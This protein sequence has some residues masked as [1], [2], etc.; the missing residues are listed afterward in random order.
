MSDFLNKYPYTDFHELNLD[1]VIERVKKLTEDWLAT[2]EEWHNT[3]EQW[4]QLYDYV[5]DYFAN[6]DVQD[7][8]NNKINQMILDGTFM[9]VVA[10]TINQTVVDATTAWLAANITQPT[11][12]VVD[13]SLTVAGAAAD[14]KITGFVRD[15]SDF[16]FD[17]LTGM[18]FNKTTYQFTFDDWIN[19]RIKDDESIVSQS[20]RLCME[21]YINVPTDQTLSNDILAGYKFIV[22]L[23]D[24]DKTRL[25]YNTYYT[26]TENTI[27]LAGAHYMRLMIDRADGT[28]ID[29]SEGSSVIF[30][31]KFAKTDKTLLIS[32]MPA[33]SQVT[34]YKIDKYFDINADLDLYKHR[35]INTTYRQGSILNPSASNR[36]TTSDYIRV[37]SGAYIKNVVH[38]GYVCAIV[39]YDKDKNVVTDE[40]R[41]MSSLNNHKINDSVCYVLF[42]IRRSDGQ[43][44]V[45][46]EGANITWYY[47]FNEPSYLDNLITKIGSHRYSV[48]HRG[49]AGFFP[50]N[51]TAAFIA[52]G[53]CGI[54]VCEADVQKTSDDVWVIM[55]DNTIDRTTDGSGDIRSM[56]YAQ[57]QTY[58]IDIGG[59]YSDAS[60]YTDLKIPTLQEYLEICKQYDMFPYVEFKKG[61]FETDITNVRA[62]L[63][64]I[65][66]LGFS[67]DQFA[68]LTV[69]KPVV[70]A[71]KEYD[72]RIIVVYVP[73]TA[74]TLQDVNDLAA[75]KPIIFSATS[76]DDLTPDVLDACNANGL[77][78][79][80]GVST[81]QD[82]YDFYNI[83]NTCIS[84]MSFDTCV[85]R[86]N[87]NECISIRVPDGSGNISVDLS[88]YI[89]TLS[90]VVE[91]SGQ[92]KASSNVTATLG[93]GPGSAD[94]GIMAQP[95]EWSD[96]YYSTIPVLDARRTFALSGT[97]LKHK[98]IVINI[99]KN[100]Y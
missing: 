52:A 99:Y 16:N 23:Y 39:G 44:I 60:V 96:F 43:D 53:M 83:N 45:P 8:I 49:L 64:Y 11:T 13:T 21:R 82:M 28:D 88:S 29:V 26:N 1:W 79:N 48:A 91:V 46:S 33:D 63:D 81:V 38:P 71:V 95:D 32:D 89:T 76:N 12:P 80:I 72:N 66:S 74:F 14:A 17:A 31:F 25:S 24:E 62:C 59:R 30:S 55:H 84:F 85:A 36:I 54:R 93:G 34:G 22:I 27:S 69:S 90:D 9:T 4:Q 7:E 86:R 58:N 19:G 65:R 78:I 47:D 37:V 40:T 5:H 20:N 94:Y 73:E 6:L 61:T 68:I 2:Q 51:S 18:V 98:R 15:A 3:Q 75:I 56:T 35:V 100:C 42:Q 67:L 92:I 41:Y 50:E 87:K 10:P 70:D 57:S 97:D 77:G